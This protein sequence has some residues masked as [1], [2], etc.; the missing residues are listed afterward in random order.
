VTWLAVLLE[1]RDQNSLI[2][3]LLTRSYS[4]DVFTFSR[5]IFRDRGIIVAAHSS[6]AR[7]GISTRQTKTY[8]KIPFGCSC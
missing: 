5:L 3:S 2:K 4:N 7:K 1:E 8:E 6:S